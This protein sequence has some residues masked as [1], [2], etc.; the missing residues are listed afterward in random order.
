LSETITI[1]IKD[2]QTSQK[3]LHD[4]TRSILET[5]CGNGTIQGSFCRGLSLCG[6][7]KIRFL[8]GAPLP[9]AEDRKF[10]DAARLREGYRLACRAR[11]K[12]DCTVELCF[13]KEA[14]MEMIAGVK[15]TPAEEKPGAA[16]E[17]R[18]VFAAADIGTTTVVMQLADVLT[19]EVLS[20]V[21]FMNPQRCYGLD[22][23][24]RIQAADGHGEEMRTCIWQVLLQGVKQLSGRHRNRYPQ[25]ELLCV[26]GNTAMLHILMGYDT[27]GLGRSPFTP[28]SL[29]ET[30]L[31]AEGIQT[32]IMPS[33]SAFV[34][35]DVAAGILETGMQGAQKVNLLIDLGT[36]G[37]MALGNRDRILACAAAAGPA[38][39]GGAEQGIY[40]ADILAAIAFLLD[41]GII[42]DNGYME[43]TQVC[44]CQ[45]KQIEVTLEKVREIQLAKAAIRAGIE[46]LIKKYGLSSYE[47]IDNV[48]LAGGFGFFL[49]DYAAVRT[50]MLPKEL[51]DRTRAI[52][53][54]A[55][56]GALG[57]GRNYLIAQSDGEDTSR[58]PDSFSN[59]YLFDPERIE[60]F[61]L[62]EEKEFQETYIRYMDFPEML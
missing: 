32:L 59:R 3:I 55:L 22:V 12:Q 4:K 31:A 20:T 50:G 28:V 14:D 45:G 26:T 53:N 21:K 34:G 58:E 49:S 60:S 6:R 1:T 11:P 25:P 57:Y 27:S 46:L 47:Q 61:N 40:G 51:K 44:T 48:Y 30:V 17:Y 39:E 16:L 7:C 33:V 41:A 37:E 9:G 38:F 42:E 8:K 36:N 18:R 35:A 62:A 2:G 5:F 29:A 56:A 24:S 15:S 13:E 23:L 10:F 54:S 43:G 52:G 19:G